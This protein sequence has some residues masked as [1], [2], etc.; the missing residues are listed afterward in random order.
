MPSGI[1]SVNG[2]LGLVGPIANGPPDN[3]ITSM[4][5]FANGL[6]GFNRVL[7]CDLKNKLD[8]SPR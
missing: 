6:S 1:D 8:R 2:W 7:M 3:W 4:E 5:T